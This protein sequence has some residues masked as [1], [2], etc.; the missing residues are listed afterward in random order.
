MSLLEVLEQ[1]K[2]VQLP[3]DEEK[4]AFYKILDKEVRDIFTLDFFR[5]AS[6]QKQTSILHVL[7]G[8]TI[9]TCTNY[10]KHVMKLMNELY[11][12]NNFGVKCVLINTSKENKLAIRISW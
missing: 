5:T 1:S 9:P 12:E 10:T 7:K 3:T 4:R 11:P 6:D 8:H 2:K